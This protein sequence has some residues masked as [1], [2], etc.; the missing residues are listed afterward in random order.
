[1]YE[2]L[3]KE[4]PHLSDIDLLNLSVFVLEYW[5]E[6]IEEYYNSIQK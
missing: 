3:K 2:R 6:C 5:K 4:F 1:M